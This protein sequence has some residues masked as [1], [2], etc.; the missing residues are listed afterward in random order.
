MKITPTTHENQS[1]KAPSDEVVSLES[2]I[3]TGALSGRTSDSNI[4]NAE[5]ADDNMAT[6]SAMEENFLYSQY[7][8]SIFMPSPNKYQTDIFSDEN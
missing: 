4:T 8:D 6:T 7:M 5:Q 3:A 2:R 1:T